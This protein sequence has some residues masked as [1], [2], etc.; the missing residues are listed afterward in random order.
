MTSRGR[1]G[2]SRQSSALPDLAYLVR[3]GEDNEELRYSL[4]SIATYLTGFRKV[5]IVGTVPSWLR[6][7][8]PLPL[9]PAPEKFAN[10][11]Q[12]LTALCARR[13]AAK[14]V[15][16]FN[17]DHFLTEP[18]DARDFPAFHLG[19]AKRY[20]DHIVRIGAVGANNTWRVA[21]RDTAAWV[22]S[23]GVPDPMCYESHTPLPFDR[24]KLGALIAEYPTDRRLAY[25]QLYPLAGAGPVG[26][27]AGNSKVQALDASQLLPKIDQP[28]PWLS[29][30]DASFA[31]G[32]IGGYVRGM[33][34]QP[35]SYEKG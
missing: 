8:E 3:P 24:A 30:N 33:F 9:A 16:V 17:D 4:R 21:V 27:D 12:S 18:V 1:A 20:V 15:I 13:D 6:N 34:R 26:V 7:V 5:W 10:M 28:M 2:T 32:M 14:T 23:R 19:S 11:R 22:E 29:S 25:P 35:S 31:N